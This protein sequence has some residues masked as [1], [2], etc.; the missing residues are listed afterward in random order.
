V[1]HG[2]LDVIEYLIQHGANVNMIDKKGITP[3]ALAKRSNKGQII[4]LLVKHG[5]PPLVDPNQK[6]KG[7]KKQPP[8]P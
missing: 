8:P 4:D 2:K 5:A 7:G 1:K 3:T 6:I